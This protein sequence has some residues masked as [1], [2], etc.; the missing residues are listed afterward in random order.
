M[1]KSI[2][3]LITILS[4]GVKSGYNTILAIGAI[5]GVVAAVTLY[6]DYRIENKITDDKFLKE[7]SHS[8]RP[9]VVFD[10][11][12]S[13]LANMGAMEYIEDINVVVE[14]GEPKKIVLSPK[15][16]LGVAPILECL[17][18]HFEIIKKQGEKYN[19]EYELKHVS[20]LLSESSGQITNHRFRI[21]IV[22]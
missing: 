15:V 11:N 12:N 6:I 8:I 20:R 1:T 16:F 7:L 2:K 10:Q 3:N 9:T 22:R 17:D 14:D 18:G 4:K 19:W 5:L 21:E 13:I